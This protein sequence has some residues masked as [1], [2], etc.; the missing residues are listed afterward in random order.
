ML[1][2]LEIVPYIVIFI[3]GITIGSFLNV[4]IY[5]IPLHQSIVTVS[6]HCMTC[7][8]KLKWYDMVP[9]FSWLLL[10]GKCRSCKSK[11]SFQYPVIESLNG[12]LYVVICLVNGMDL[13]SLIYCLM[14]SA[15]L[16]LSLIDWRTYEIPP[17]INGFLFILGVAAAV[18]DR[19][20]LLSHLAGMVCV[21]GF[22]G[23]LYL[24]SRGRAIGG[25]DIKLMFACGLILGWKQI[26][27]AFLLGCI[28]GSVIHLI[29]IRVQG[30]GH[31][32]A[33]GPYLSAGIF[34]A[35]LW[36]NAWI[37]WYISLL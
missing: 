33:M 5:R 17:G 20:N 36:G 11:I 12:I 7:G 13:F 27:L 32:L 6:S 1:L 28:I 22:L 3:F 15:L 25:G 31:V 8:R 19:G 14:T 16:T 37:S 34:L 10:G 4:C 30:E 26:I 29:R 23:I 9:V 18:L 2:L 35:A 21:S 24:I